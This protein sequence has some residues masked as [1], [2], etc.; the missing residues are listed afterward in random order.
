MFADLG[1]N[2]KK[3]VGQKLKDVTPGTFNLIL[4]EQQASAV[5]KNCF[6]LRLDGPDIEKQSENSYILSFN[7]DVLIVIEKTSNI[8]DMPTLTGLLYG[9]FDAGFCVPSYGHF[10]VLGQIIT[11]N[12]GQIDKEAP[13]LCTAVSGDFYMTYEA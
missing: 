7:L 12:Y 11:A 10:S 1:I 5:K 3:E 9:L 13:L 4:E 8:Y 6:Y 2:I